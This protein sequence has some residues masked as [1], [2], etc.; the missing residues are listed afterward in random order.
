[1]GR[2]LGEEE[3][4]DGGERV[5]AEVQRPERGRRARARVIFPFAAAGPDE[6]GEGPEAVARRG[7]LLQLWAEAQAAGERGGGRKVQGLA[8]PQD[9]PLERG[10]GLVGRGQEE[11]LVEVA[12]GGALRWI[13]WGCV[14]L[15]IFFLSVD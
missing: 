3:A 8:V 11:E 6:G 7:Q 10:P 9:Q 12:E 1:M 2:R 5:P 4:G 15:L 13:D 14:A